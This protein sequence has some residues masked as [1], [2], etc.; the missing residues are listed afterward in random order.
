[1]E[2]IVLD[3]SSPP[4]STNPEYTILFNLMTGKKNF[5]FRGC[6]WPNIAVS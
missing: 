3:M 5:Y 2:G 4:I 1:M 6:G